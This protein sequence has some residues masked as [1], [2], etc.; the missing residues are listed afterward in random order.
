MLSDIINLILIP[1]RY[2]ITLLFD[3]G[4]ENYLGVPVI[5]IPVT[6]IITLIVIKA[7]LNPVA[8]ASAGRTYFTHTKADPKPQRS[9]AYNMRAA[10]QAAEMR[11][12]RG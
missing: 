1:I 10:N 5:A 4:L 7:L 9:A 12:N 6:G 11:R 3:D 2:F 8:I